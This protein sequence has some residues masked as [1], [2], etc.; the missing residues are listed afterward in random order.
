MEF[1]K[2]NSVKTH[3]NH[4]LKNSENM[5]FLDFMEKTNINTTEFL[6]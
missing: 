6:F 1:L 3:L 5:Y 4:N 2:K